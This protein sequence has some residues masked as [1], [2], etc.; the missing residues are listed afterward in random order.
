M[1]TGHHHLQRRKRKLK[2]YPMKR[3]DIYLFLLKYFFVIQQNDK[4]VIFLSIC[5]QHGL[6]SVVH[7]SIE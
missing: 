1:R 2:N 4:L 6:F 3:T 7:L 5:I